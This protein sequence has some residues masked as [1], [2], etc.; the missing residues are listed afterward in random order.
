M[1]ATIRDD[2]LNVLDMQHITP[3]SKIRDFSDV[4]SS[5]IWKG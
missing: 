5:G 2:T 1:L 3:N 4:I